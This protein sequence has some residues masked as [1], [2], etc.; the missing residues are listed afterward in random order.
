MTALAPVKLVLDIL[1]M[2]LLHFLRKP[3]VA[4]L[5]EEVPGVQCLNKAIDDSRKMLHGFIVPVVLVS[6]LSTGLVGV[7]VAGQKRRDERRDRGDELKANNDHLV[8]IFLC[9][10][11]SMGDNNQDMRRELS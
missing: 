11:S 8:H 4:L 1:E 5:F 6:H 10:D 9:I 7:A 3:A 2:L